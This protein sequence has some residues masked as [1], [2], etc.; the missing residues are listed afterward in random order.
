MKLKKHILVVDSNRICGGCGFE[1]HTG[2][3][4]YE[5]IFCLSLV[6][7]I[8]SANQVVMSRSLTVREDRSVLTLDLS[9]NLPC[10]TGKV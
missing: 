7:T 6:G 9:V 2:S 8:S 1:T 10:Y 4:Y 5:I 3:Y